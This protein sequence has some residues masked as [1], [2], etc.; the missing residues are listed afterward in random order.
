MSGAEGILRRVILRQVKTTHILP[1]M[2][3]EGSFG[4]KGRIM[5]C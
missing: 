5:Q 3:I 1:I 4:F 2:I